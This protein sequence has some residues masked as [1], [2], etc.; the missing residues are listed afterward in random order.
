MISIYAAQHKEI[1]AEFFYG[2]GYCTLRNLVN[3][4]ALNIPLECLPELARLFAFVS[5]DD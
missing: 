3:G 4:M 5:S 2:D 1:R